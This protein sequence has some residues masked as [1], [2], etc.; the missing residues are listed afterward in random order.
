MMRM[1]RKANRRFVIHVQCSLSFYFHVF[2]SHCTCTLSHR[3]I[4]RLQRK[5]REAVEA[6]EDDELMEEQ[7]FVE[8][9]KPRKKKVGSVYFTDIKFPIIY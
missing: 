3:V 7:E 9:E 6:T 2:G 8:E 5:Q 1:A 4:L